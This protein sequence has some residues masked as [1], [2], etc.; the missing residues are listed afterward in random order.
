MSSRD[1]FAVAMRGWVD[2]FMRHSMRNF[3]RYSRECGLSPSQIGALL[4]LHHKK[5]SGVTDLGDTL[6][7]SSAAASQMLERLVQQGLILRSEDPDD[8]RAKH[9]V[10]TE[11][12]ARI[13]QESMHA[14]QGWVEDLAESLTDSEK[15]QAVAVLNLLIEKIKRLRL[16]EEPKR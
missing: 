15:E 14:R 11:K 6:G 16:P 1:P 12:G 2:V 8:R 4:Q 10:L 13:A 9:L 7:V 5:D 3:F